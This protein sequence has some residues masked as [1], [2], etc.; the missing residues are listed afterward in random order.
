MKIFHC[1]FGFRTGGSETM[2]VDLANEQA[3]RG[4]DVT[5]L[6][7][8]TDISPGLL[9]TL[10]P[11]VHRILIGRQPGSCNPLPV[12]RLNAILIKHRPDVL[13]LHNAGIT[14]MILPP[15]RRHIVTT[16][17]TTG[18]DLSLGRG[19]SRFVA[20]SPTVKE[21]ALT[22]HPGTRIEII[23]NA[24]DFN[25]IS[26]RPDSPHFGKCLKIVQL[27][28]LFPEIKGQDLLIRAL[29]ILRREGITDI[30]AEFIGAGDGR[31]DLEA[32]GRAEGVEGQLAFAGSLSRKDTYR[33]LSGYDLMVHPSRIEGFG[34]AIIEGIAAGL[35]VVVP[36]RGAPF[37]ITR[38]GELA[39]TFAYGDA[40]SLAD[41]LRAI[42]DDYPAAV[43]HVAA[44]MK[45]A[46]GNFSLDAMTDS[47]LRLYETL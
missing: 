47:Y 34:L 5:L 14:G 33:R 42:H 21:E 17:H 43:R 16:L 6:V 23:S 39:H 26:R 30:T 41:T 35:P 28:R 12:A 32:L 3:R 15:L 7:V 37:E 4:H 45:Y 13:H 19:A 2:V 24:I 29:G 1:F 9:A 8:N 36:D 38:R 22:R 25:A 11:A 31:T 44:A 40:D 27:G 46:R 20:I 10:S 18:I